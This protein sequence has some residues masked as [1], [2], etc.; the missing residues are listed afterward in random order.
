MPS[1]EPRPR[2]K[3]Q[4]ITVQPGISSS[5]LIH[6]ENASRAFRCCSASFEYVLQPFIATCKVPLIVN[7]MKFHQRGCVSA[8]IIS[9]GPS[10]VLKDCCVAHPAFSG[11]K[12]AET[13]LEPEAG[14]CFQTRPVPGNR[15]PRYDFGLSQGPITTSTLQERRGLRKQHSSSGSSRSGWR[16]CALRHLLTECQIAFSTRCT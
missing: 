13:N 6:C 8:S 11:W 7:Y 14:A 2:H 1:A 4:N 16:R 15:E 9:Y 12:W 3:L 5:I 10:L